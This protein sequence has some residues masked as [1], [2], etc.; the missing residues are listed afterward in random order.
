[1]SRLF[2]KK[3]ALITGSTRGIG[4]QIANDIEKEGGKVITTGTHNLDF[5]NKKKTNEFFE[6]IDK[7]YEKIDVLVNNAGINFIDYIYDYKEENFEKLVNVNLKGVYLLTKLVS[8][9]MIKNK[10]GRIVNI[11]SIFGTTTL[12]KR[13]IYSMTKSGIEGLTRGMALDL[14]EYNILANSVAPGFTLTDLTKRVLGKDGIKKIEKEIPVKRLA[15]T[16][17]ISNTVLYF[18]SDL[19]SYITGQNIIVDGGY[20]VR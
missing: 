8:K 5:L 15:S 18:A 13:S 11:S 6:K 4:K 17:D 19:N 2:D 7:D 14:A 1:M 20:V 16:K 3:I 10:Y 12:T 9:K